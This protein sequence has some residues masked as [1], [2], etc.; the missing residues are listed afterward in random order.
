MKTTEG[1][2]RETAKATRMKNTDMY[3]DIVLF[4][5]DTMRSCNAEQHFKCVVKIKGQFIKDI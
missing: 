4:V 3:S 2:R 5:S 1:E